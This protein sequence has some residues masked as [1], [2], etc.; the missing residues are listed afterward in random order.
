M[1]E[2]RSSADARY[3]P[4]KF[5]EEITI[6]DLKV[7]PIW[8]WCFTLALLGAEDGPIGGDETSMR[9]LLD[10]K[11]VEPWM[12]EPFILLQVKGTTRFASGLY[13]QLGRKIVSLNIEPLLSEE[14]TKLSRV[15]GLS[16]PTDWVA[17]L[18]FDRRTGQRRV[19]LHYVRQGRGRSLTSFAVAPTGS[20]LDRGLEIR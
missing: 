17:P 6:E 20:R 7:N 4:W 10:S 13:D 8:L 16:V 11:N 14:D 19:S 9:P 1:D 15:G 2:D 3:G 18:T 12:S 5:I